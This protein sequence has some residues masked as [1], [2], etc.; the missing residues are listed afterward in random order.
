MTKTNSNAPEF[1]ITQSQEESFEEFKKTLEKDGIKF[2]EK[3]VAF[4]QKEKPG[5]FKGNIPDT[6]MCINELSFLVGSF[7]SPFIRNGIIEEKTYFED[8]RNI[9]KEAIDY[10]KKVN[11]E[12]DKIITK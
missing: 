1:K 9:M 12:Q 5:I 11:E 2:R 8:V 7:M 6:A 10:Q 4:L 3:V